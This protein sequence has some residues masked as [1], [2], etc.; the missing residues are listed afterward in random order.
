VVAE[1]GRGAHT[2]VYHIRR[3]GVDYAVKVLQRP[4]LSD[5]RGAAAF[6]REAALLARV[7][8][9]GVPK[10]F[11][12]GVSRG[13]PYLVLEL[14]NGQSLSE[15]LETG[16]LGEPALLHVAMNVAAALGAAHRAGLVHRDIKP[17]NI[18]ITEDGQ[19][20]LIDFGLAA[21]GLPEPTAS[22]VGTLRYTAPEQTGMLSR[23][24]DGRA[25]LYALGVVLFQCATGELPFSADDV[26]ELIAMHAVLP[27]QIHGC[28]VRSCPAGWPS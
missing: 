22:V 21:A 17:A 2:A 20:L 8:H 23:P 18:M 19:V 7:N 15:L 14:L 13:H 5:G 9:P 6:C 28:C 1:L 3:S 27:C 4:I 24:V 10:V 25:D 12:A 16:A 26:G 11:E